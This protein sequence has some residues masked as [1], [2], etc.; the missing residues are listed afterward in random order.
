MVGCGAVLTG[1]CFFPAMC[2]FIK[3][4]IDSINSS[5]NQV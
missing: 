2:F 4:R 5:K 3:N 1:R